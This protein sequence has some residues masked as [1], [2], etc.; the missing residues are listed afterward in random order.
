[1]DWL[2]GAQMVPDGAP[3]STAHVNQVIVF[4]E[5]VKQGEC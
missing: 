5:C 1:M 3:V 2:S 4:M